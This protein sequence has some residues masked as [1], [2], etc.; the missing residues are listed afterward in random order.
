MNDL[1]AMLRSSSKKR[2]RRAIVGRSE[3]DRIK[4]ERPPAREGRM[5]Y[6]SNVAKELGVSTSAITTAMQ[7][8]KPC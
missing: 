1:V 3:I 6:Y 4:R 8:A 2:K 5:Q 7:R